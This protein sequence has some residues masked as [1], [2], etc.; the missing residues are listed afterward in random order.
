MK[1]ALILDVLFT[2]SDPLNLYKCL[3]NRARRIGNIRAAL[4]SLL[5]APQQGSQGGAKK[6]PLNV[7]PG[8]TRTNDLAHRVMVVV[9][10]CA[11]EEDRARFRW[12]FS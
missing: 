12:C 11:R 9:G 7:A 1:H 4:P 6:S 3:K 5:A 10:T 8:T 2:F